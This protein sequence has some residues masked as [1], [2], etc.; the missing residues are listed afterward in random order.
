MIEQ[1]HSMHYI[2][3]RGKEKDLTFEDVAL[4]GLA[5]DGGLFLCSSFPDL[6]NNLS[7]LASYNYQRLVSF[8]FSQFIGETSHI[9]IEKLVDNAY[10]DFEDEIIKIRNFPQICMAELFH[11]PTLS[12][13]D[14]ALQVVAQF[15]DFFL[16]RKNAT[17]NI[18]GATSGDT[19]SAAI[20]ALK[21]K[22][23]IQVFMLY[24]ENKISQLQKL[25]MVTVNESNIHCIAIKGSFDDAQNLVKSTLLDKEISKN[26][27]LGAVNSI[28]WLRIV[29]QIVYYFY[30]GLIFI[31]KFPQLPL[32]FSVPTGNF[33][34][35]FAAYCAQKMGL[36]IKKLI[37]ACNEND[38]LHRVL[39]TGIYDKKK[40]IPTIT[41]AMDIQ[42]S[43]NF[44]RLLFQLSGKDTNWVKRKMLEL[45]TQGKFQL[46][47]TFLQKFRHYFQSVT[48]SQIQTRQTIKEFY[49][50][51]NI[52]L[53]PHTAIAVHAA[54]KLMPHE[55]VV[56]I[57]T[58]HAAKFSETIYETL[59][60][61]PPLPQSL[62]DLDKKKQRFHTIQP[63]ISYLK[64]IIYQK[65]IKT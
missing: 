48:V 32:I 24:P 38:I 65:A 39:T 50:K 8:V 10:T 16:E 1:A 15:M 28:N 64:E 2:S 58:A 13:K 62:V 41:P 56:C 51:N 9:P 47:E 43:S 26:Y 59:N 42:I 57:A 27:S 33:G 14:Y 5:Q 40:V 36:P 29:G 45:Q 6:S 12:F 60:I 25:Q 53:D 4:R 61:Q 7:E 19:G 46:E 21:G 54:Q 35:I 37:I 20:Q 34:N 55:K 17:F 23:N 31:R 49:N 44:E 63:E 30:I 3:T 18:V 52:I 11:G 22:K